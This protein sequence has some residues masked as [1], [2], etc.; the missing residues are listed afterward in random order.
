MARITNSEVASMEQNIIND[1]YLKTAEDLNKRKEELVAK[2]RQMLLEKY[3]PYIDKLPKNMLNK[4]Y[5]YQLDINY[6][7]NRIK[8]ED[9]R[10]TANHTK[11]GVYN[12]HKYLMTRW[13]TDKSLHELEYINETWEINFKLPEINPADDGELN[14]DLEEEAGELCKDLLNFIKE[15][16]KMEHY[17]QESIEKNRTHKKLRDIWPSSLQKYIPVE[18]KTTRGKNTEAVEVNAPN[19]LNER[20]TTNLLED[21]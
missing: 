8:K 2:N 12:Q 5:S 6:P 17:L 9:D 21:N 3:Q 13:G 20:L 10:N 15:K 7:W 11:T 18:S 1:L 16:V 14:P 4:R 19:F